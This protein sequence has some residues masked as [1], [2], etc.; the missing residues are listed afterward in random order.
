MLGEEWAS[1]WDAENWAALSHGS[2]SFRFSCR[3]GA[4]P[5]PERRMPRRPG[6]SPASGEPQDFWFFLMSQCCCLM[7]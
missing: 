2:F 6:D 5:F 4:Y 1:Q 3:T 7:G